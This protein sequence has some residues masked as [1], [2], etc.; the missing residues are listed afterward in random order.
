MSHKLNFSE[1][2]PRFSNLETAF[3]AIFNTQQIKEKVP[4]GGGCINRCYRITLVNG[5]TFFLKENGAKVHPGL[6]WAEAVG[7]WSLNASG[8]PRL[9]K[10]LGVV[11]PSQ[12]SASNAE[13]SNQYLLLEYLKSSSKSISFW[14]DLGHSLANLHLF[15]SQ[16]SNNQVTLFGFSQNNYIGATV[17]INTWE[18]EWIHFFREHR[19]KFQLKMARDKGLLSSSHIKKSEILLKK[20]DSILFSPSYPELLHGDLWRGNVHID[21]HGH[22]VI[23]DP[24]VYYGHGEAD[25][26]MTELFG[27]FPLSFYESYKSIYPIEP[28]AD[29]RK[30][31]Y[32]LYHLLNHL[33]LFGSGYMRNCLEII[34]KFS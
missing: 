12:N 3:Q 29:E 10:V 1:S 22:P 24:A 18:R 9:P 32:N 13:N 34:N 11:E 17:Q 15:N 28:N 25:L 7:L 31:I 21:E 30:E 19:L 26:A 5:S 27:H 2:I 8:S 6:F 33:N 23:I 16:L 4:V 20:L 14:E